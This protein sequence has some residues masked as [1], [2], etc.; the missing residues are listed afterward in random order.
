MSKKFTKK[1]LTTRYKEHRENCLFDQEKAMLPATQPIVE[2]IIENDRIRGE[3][4]N[5]RIQISSMQQTIRDYEDM[6]YYR[7]DTNIERKSFVRKCPNPDCRGFLSTQWKC[8]LCERKTCKECNECMSTDDDEH[9][10][11]P[12]NVE[13]AKLLA[14]DCKTCP[15]CGEM[16]FKIDGCFARDTPILL[17]NGSVKMSQ[18]I[19]I[20]DQLVGDDGTFRTVLDTCAGT[21][22]LFKVEHEDGTFYIVNSKHILVT[23]Q[24]NGFLFEL[25][26]EKYLSLDILEQVQLFAVR[27]TSTGLDALAF[28][29]FPTGKRGEYYGWKVDANQRFLH[30]DHT[31]LH[32]CD[33]MYCTQC[34]TAFSWRTGRVE[35]GTVHNPHYFEWLKKQDKL[36]NQ[37][38]QEMVPRCGRE[39]DHHLI[40]RMINCPNFTYSPM[41]LDVCRNV[42]HFQAV[43]LP[44]FQTDRFNDNQDL[45]VS[46]L[47]NQLT[48]Q[49]FRTTLQKREKSREKNE[50]LYR[51]FAMMIQCVTEI[52]Y[53]YVEERKPVA[54]YFLEL[55]N[56]LEYVN[57]C[58]HN[59]S[60]VYSCR[61]YSIDPS[62]S[63]VRL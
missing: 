3:I 57:E 42:I 26:V 35:T 59:I 24:R 23:Q 40:R 50:E 11:D 58:L 51:L 49:A 29:V 9:K 30:A 33:Q 21:D 44:R 52:V 27:K 45:R 34:H 28:R 32:N 48:E 22:Q 47:Q 5:L 14:Q 46:F 15:K 31:V 37:L 20:G 1:F 12:N 13:T 2:R 19:R 41:M 43:E 56:L 53:R 62:V 63:L 60:K 18:S 10:C 8:N 7:R 55:D 16:I 6:L 4:T 36:D 17:R 61:R 39:I 38:V 54:H 25:S